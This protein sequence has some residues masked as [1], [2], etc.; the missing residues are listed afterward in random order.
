MA[1][2]SCFYAVQYC[3]WKGPPKLISSIQSENKVSDHGLEEN[4]H[5]WLVFTKMLVS[6]PKTGS[7]LTGTL[8]CVRMCTLSSFQALTWRAAVSAHLPPP[9]PTNPNP[10]LSHWYSLVWP[11]CAQIWKGMCKSPLYPHILGHTVSRIER[12][13]VKTTPFHSTG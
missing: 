7:L 6:M 12:A 13:S 4:V 5:F 3:I 2:L 8:L 1:A 9:P 11:L 10:S